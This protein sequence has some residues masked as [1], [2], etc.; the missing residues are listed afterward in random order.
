MKEFAARTT[1]GRYGVVIGIKPFKRISRLCLKAGDKETG[2]II[3]G[4]YTSDLTNA[5]VTEATPPPPDSNHGH[6]YFERGVSGLAGLLRRRW[7]AKRRTY[8]L[9]EWHFHPANIIEPSREDFY[10]MGQIAS[11]KEYSCKEPIL[12]VVGR[13]SD[14]NVDSLIKAY[15]C[16]SDEPPIELLKVKSAKE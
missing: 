4:Y 3:I 2:G 9:G 5:L 10:Q 12:L 14:E 16:P 11:A 15:V 7:V 1:D 8:Y 13:R 6:M